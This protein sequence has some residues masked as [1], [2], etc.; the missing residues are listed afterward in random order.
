[1]TASP[2]KKTVER[3]RGAP[4]ATREIALAILNGFDG[5]YRAF[6]YVSQQAKAHFE[7]GDWPWMQKAVRERIA[8]YDRHVASTAGHLRDTLNAAQLKD[9]DWQQIKQHYTALLAT[10]KQPECAETFFNSVSCKILHRDYF[11]NDYIFVRPGVA[12]EHM[13]SDP[14]SYRSYY[15]LRDGLRNSLRRLL[16]DFGL[17]SPFVDVE[18][19]LRRLILAARTALPRPFRVEADC[20][21]HVLGSLFFRNK[22]AYIVGRLINANRPYPFAVPILRNSKGQV[23]IDAL[24]FNPDQLA[25]LFS[26]SRAYFLVDMEVPSAYV[27]FLHTLLPHKPLAELY[28]MVG[29]QKQG[30]TLFYRDLLHHLKHSDDRFVIAPGT[31]GLVMIVF[32]LPSYPYVFKVI[33]D[34]MGHPKKTNRAAVVE[35]YQLVKQHDRVGRMADVWEYSQVAFPKARVSETVLQELR[36]LAPSVFEDEGDRIVIR[37]VYIERRMTPLDLYLQHRSGKAFEV[38][39]VDYGN[40]IKDM[41]SANIFP[42]DMLYKNF[43]VTRLGR[44]VF[45]DYDEVTYL[46]ECNFRRIPNAPSPQEELAAEPWYSVGPDDVFPEEFATFL[47]GD[48]RVREVFLKHHADLLDPAAW[49]AKQER[50]RRGSVE[51]VFPYSLGIRFR[52][53]FKLKK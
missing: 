4:Y 20:Q 18:R 47:L 21:I 39:I 41:A 32:T 6:R 10:H 1:M 7:N 3:R 9:T 31:K 51:N 34:A 5:H 23:Y 50:L 45:Y 38:A 29:L 11:R 30:K 27:E 22:G 36:T 2:E 44:I 43:G 37:H 48:P 12:T 25:V 24:L 15:P 53:L 52:H 14:P 35:K 33:R 28:S 42:G 19:D 13:D 26:F 17:A 46:T 49:Q 16:I 40:A 8:Y